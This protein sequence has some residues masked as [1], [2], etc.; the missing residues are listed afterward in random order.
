M[1]PLAVFLPGWVGDAV[2][3]T[4]ALRALRSHFA[5]ARVFG[6]MKPNVAGVLGGGDWFDEVAPDQGGAGVRNVGSIAWR[7]R[8]RV[9]DVAV[10]F[11]NSFRTAL[12]AW[13]GGCKR[14]IGF[15]RYARS[16]F[17]TDAVPPVL[18]ERGRVT[19]S[20]VLD[21]YN[22]LAERA[23]CPAASRRMEL[24][25]TDAAEAAARRVW[26]TPGVGE[27]CEVGR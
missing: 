1:M 3:A 2:M 21:A 25:T 10:L 16:L 6:V 9:I 15:A 26:D 18:D 11:P 19:P 5:G 7:L 8:K 20:P 4:P 13:L 27:R 17:L 12:A 22:L 24:F 23:G 14:R